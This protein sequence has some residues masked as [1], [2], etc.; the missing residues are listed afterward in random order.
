[1]HFGAALDSQRSQIDVASTLVGSKSAEY[2]A[3][4]LGEAGAL[5]LSK[6][7][8]LRLPLPPVQVL[9]TVVRCPHPRC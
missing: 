4:T 1:M 6:A 8:T 3:L 5:L 9:S 2:V 7:G